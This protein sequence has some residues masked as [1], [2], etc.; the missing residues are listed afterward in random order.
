MNH[1]V[2]IGTPPWSREDILAAIDEFESLYEERP[3]RGDPHGMQAPH[4]FATW[5]MARAVKPALVVESGIWKGQSTWLLEQACPEAEI[6]SIDVRLDFR[7]YISE[8]VTYSDRD[9]S[10]HDWSELDPD[11]SLVFFDDHQNA[12]QRLQQCL[13][14]GFR[15]VIFEDN[16][17]PGKG[18]C[19]SLRHAFSGA[20]FV[21]AGS[22]APPSPG[23]HAKLRTRI[24]DWLNMDPISITPQ[25]SRV[26]IAPNS[27]DA[28]MLGKH[29]DVYCEFPPVFKSNT[30]RWGDPWVDDVYPTPAP[31][32][33][34]DDSTAHPIFSQQAKN[35]TW[36]CY[37]RLRLGAETLQ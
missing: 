31:L 6:I 25:Y 37:A 7:E 14:F 11:R 17:P 28:A 3:I 16:Y 4:L 35:Y 29:L 2:T 30:T 21:P 34:D 10:E 9:F 33:S 27:H 19:Y 12:Y 24:A 26:K 32:L 5:F 20:G 13:W 22:N 23:I 8:R 1:P 36:I 15:H 18:D